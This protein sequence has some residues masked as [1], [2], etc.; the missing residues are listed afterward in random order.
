[1]VHFPN[2]AKLRRSGGAL[3]VIIES[4]NQINLLL[5][6][7]ITS[8]PVKDVRHGLQPVELFLDVLVCK[9]HHP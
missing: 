9:Q 5:H 2:V 6:F 8:F 4:I 3:G 7:I 1:M